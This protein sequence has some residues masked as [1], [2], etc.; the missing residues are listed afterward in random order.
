MQLLQT[1]LEAVPIVKVQLDLQAPAEIL[2]NRTQA[3]E[4][5]MGDMRQIEQSLDIE[6]QEYYQ[7]LEEEVNRLKEYESMYKG[8]CK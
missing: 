7:E 4:A 6:W 1:Y 8:L 5:A 3:M 2:I